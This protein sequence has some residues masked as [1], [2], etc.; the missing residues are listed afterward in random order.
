VVTRLLHRDDPYLLE[1]DARV[2]DRLEHE[3]RPAVVL[4]QTAFYAESGGQPWDLGTLDGVPVVAVVERAGAILHVLGA[5]LAAPAVH[6]SIDGERRLDHRQQH[7]GQHLLSRA[8]LE[9]FEAR[10]LSFHLGAEV[11]TVDLDRAVTEAQMERAVRRTNEVVW[12]ARPVRVRTVSRWEAEALGVAVPEEAGD[13]V[14]L[15]EAEGF[16]LQPCGG[17]HPRSTA[18]V[19]CVA[20]VG[21]ERYKGGSRVRF[22]CGHRVLALLREQGQTLDRTSG[23]LSS[24]RT[25]LPDTVQRLLD[26]AATARKEAATLRE[27]V[28][29][30]EARQLYA[31]AVA[32]KGPPSPGNPVVVVARFDGRDP[33]EV[34]ALA[35]AVV[36]EGP[37]VALLGTAT[38]K[39][40]LVFAQTPGVGL[41]VPGLLKEAVALV[42]GRGG[43]RGDLARG[44]GDTVARLDDA[45]GLARSAAT[46]GPS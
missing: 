18:E 7:H 13:A 14:R 25:D 10:T 34:Q 2:V 35:Q 40:H 36:A 31:A 43:G 30:F 24:S 21:Q 32:A 39:A 28:L 19:G 5:P 3:G 33:E 38:G 20:V 37:C 8:L 16:D 12:G 22:V 15:V 26:Q 11:S 42:G 23:L 41:D 44:G 17:T 45:L 46:R 27:R 9:L 4:D 1:F 6:G 29:A